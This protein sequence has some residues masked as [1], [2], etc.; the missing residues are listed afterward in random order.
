M[1]VKVNE[2]T[3]D[4]TLENEKTI[5]DFLKAFELEASKN[6]ATT[7]GIKLNG[8]EINQQNF[9][10]ILDE[11]IKEDTLIELS[12]ISKKDILSFFATDKENFD[13]IIAKIENIPVLLQEG[14]DSDVNAIIQDM[15][16][17]IDMFCHNS[18]LSA[19]FPELYNQIKIDG[20]LKR[21]IQTIPNLVG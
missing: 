16:N 17:E 13:Q 18:T 5:G 1:I 3:V 15:A 12:V 10:Q 7:F 20:K 19:L 9:D 21:L 2:Q 6:E 8:N 4:V 11:E 14:K